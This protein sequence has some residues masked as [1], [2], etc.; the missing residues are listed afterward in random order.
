LLIFFFIIVSFLPCIN[1]SA[2]Y[3]K[4]IENYLD[5]NDSVILDSLN[6]P[7][8][9]MWLIVSFVL[10]IPILLDILINIYNSKNEAF[11]G[12]IISYTLFLMVIM[13]PNLAFYISLNEHNMSSAYYKKLAR[14]QGAIFYSQ[15]LTI[16]GSLFCS[17]FGRNYDKQKFQNQKTVSISIERFTSLFLLSFV[18]YKTFHYLSMVYSSNDSQAQGLFIVSTIFLILGMIIML[19]LT[20]KVVLYLT[21]FS[22][23]LIFDDSDKMRDF[24][25]IIL[26]ICFAIGTFILYAY[27]GEI[28]DYQSVLNESALVISG[29]LLIQIFLLV[30]I[31]VVSIRCYIREAEIKRDKLEIR[32]NLIR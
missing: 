25:N 6:N 12:K 3:E 13:I 17:M 15:S 32:L 7:F 14:I 30:F 22:N 2:E 5:Y 21:Q 24:Y 10:C 18:L 19:Y 26:I 9:Q 27:S 20:V 31:Q 4:N 8:Y 29:Y 28:S 11:S 1:F 23:N 16:I